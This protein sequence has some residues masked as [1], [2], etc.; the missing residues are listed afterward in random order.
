MKRV[1]EIVKEKLESW[2]MESSKKVKKKG[3]RISLNNVPKKHSIIDFD[4][5]EFPLLS[6]SP[7]QRRCDYL[8]VANG[9]GNEDW[10]VPI[11]LKKGSLEAGQALRQLRAGAAISEQIVASP[12]RIKFRPI[13][14]YGR[15]HKAQ[16]TKLKSP[17]YKVRFHGVSEFIRLVGCG[18]TLAKV[19]KV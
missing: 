8:F 15:I 11:E 6:L 1:A 16:R 14:A 9:D 17:Q 13:A 18:D 3:C 12:T 7:S 5:P 10:I 4:K 2:S 19:L